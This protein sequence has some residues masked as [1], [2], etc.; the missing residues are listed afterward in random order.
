MDD[1]GL[2][3]AIVVGVG[4]LAQWLAWRLRIPGILLLL[5]A[6]VLMGQ[7]V[8]NPDD[9]LGKLLEPVVSLSVA[10]VLFEGG[11]GLQL[12]EL[13]DSRAIVTRLILVGALV[14]WVLATLGG[15]L[16][17]SDVR[18]AAL[19]G[20]VLTVTGPTVVGPL[21][22]SIRPQGRVAAVAKWEGI[23]IDPVG[24]LLAVLVFEAV[25]ATGPG[26]AFTVVVTSLL[27]TVLVSVPLAIAAAGL[28]VVVMQRHWIAEHLEVPL[29]FALVLVAH[30]VSNA[31]QPEAGLATV[32]LLGV[33]LANQRFVNVRH[34]A[35]FKEHLTI[36]LISTLFIL[37]GSRVQ[38]AEI[39]GLGVW[40][41]VFLVLL[42][43]VVRP[44]SVFVSLAGTSLD[45][46]DKAF[47]SWLAPRGIVAAAVSSVFAL[48]AS[49]FGGDLPEEDLDRLVPVVFLAVIGTVSLYGLTSV[50]VARWLGIAGPEPEGVMILGANELGIPLAESLA[51]AGLD[52]LV[53]D[54]NAENVRRARMLGLPTRLGNALDESFAERLDLRAVGRLF[55]LTPNNDVN[56]LA[57]IKYA[58]SF[59]RKAV[60]R[61]AATAKDAE[62]ALASKQGDSLLAGGFDFAVLTERIRNGA[63]F[64]QTALTEEFGVEQFRDRY[65][66]TAVV[67]MV[68][69]SDGTLV[70]TVSGK[71]VP[72]AG[73]SVLALV[74]PVDAG[75]RRDVAESTS[76]G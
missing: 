19:A 49:E 24:A 34:V 31:V 27:K 28:F 20:A 14:T 1:K 40:G 45:W 47:L 66:E 29:T 67:F 32:T 10:I 53:V 62:E 56:T 41:L 18:V 39:L 33:L 57:T 60:F 7:F 22:R 61:V 72:K 59:G 73:E 5:L 4:L 58:E 63:V 46:R 65:G 35:E 38:P 12:S 48:H 43:V 9:V 11:L 25:A 50:R 21:L 6:G 42:I 26:A 36:L 13:T 75:E 54:S 70:P 37:L 51:G 55:A 68:L 64:K 71:R 30:T 3:L 17:F 2:Y 8:A 69:T 76:P 23:V 74:D 15:L 16:V 52:V 44:A